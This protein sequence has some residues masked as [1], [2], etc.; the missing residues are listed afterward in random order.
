MSGT[1]LIN[2]GMKFRLLLSGTIWSIL[3]MD[4][5]GMPSRLSGVA[6]GSTPAN[7][8]SQV[9]TNYEISQTSEP[10]PKKRKQGRPRKDNSFTPPTNSST[11]PQIPTRRSQQQLGESLQTPF[12]SIRNR[13]ADA[14]WSTGSQTSD[15]GD[16]ST[17]ADTL[18]WGLK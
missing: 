14:S 3:M 9:E 4:A 8:S 7:A 1:L 15:V 5:Q 12:Q 17:I 16:S 10:S 6:T 18:K 2:F 13:A 11:Q